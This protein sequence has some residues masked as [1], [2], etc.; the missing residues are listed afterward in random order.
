M[1]DL[2]SRLNAIFA[3]VP[4]DND[5]RAAITSAAENKVASNPTD[6]AGAVDSAVHTVLSQGGISSGLMSRL[7]LAN[8]VAGM[9]GDNVSLMKAVMGADNVNSLREMSNR[10][11]P[12]P[13]N[14][15]EDT[16]AKSTEQTQPAAG[17]PTEG[18]GVAESSGDLSKA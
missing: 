17:A 1:H 12:T 6:V 5:V 14:I 18:E 8:S 7:T 16:A 4:V 11:D 15:T 9:S 2:Q 13:I 10:V 3:A